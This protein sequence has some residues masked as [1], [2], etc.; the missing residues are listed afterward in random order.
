M[1]RGKA[2]PKRNAVN[3]E[4]TMKTNPLIVIIAV[5]CGIRGVLIA[6][7]VTG[8][9]LKV[10]S[11]HILEAVQ[12]SISGGLN[13]TIQS[14]AFRSAI[15]GGVYNQV[16][17]GATGSVI[18]GG[19]GNTIQT[20]AG[21]ST[22]AGGDGNTIE[23]GAYR[24]TIA[25]GNGNSVQ[26]N[27]VYCT[28]GGGLLNII[29]AD[30]VESFIGG[31]YGNTIQVGSGNSTIA[32]GYFN[33]IQ[34]DARWATISGGARNVVQTNAWGAT[35]GGGAANFIFANARGSTIGGGEHNTNR[36]WGGTIGGGFNNTIGQ[37]ASY[38]V[39]PGGLHNEVLAEFGLAAGYRAK[40]LNRGTFVWADDSSDVDFASTTPYQFLIRASG[41]VGIGTASPQAQLDVVSSRNDVLRLSGGV[42]ATLIEFNAASTDDFKLG[43]VTSLGG[44]GLKNMTDDRYDLFVKDDGNVGIGKTDP[45]AKLDVA[46]K[47]NCTVLELTSDRAQKSDFAPVDRRAILDQLARL[48]I[49]TWHYTNEP[50]VRHIGPVAQDFK[51]AFNVGSDDKHIA[52]VDA[53]GVALAAI[54]ALNDK[55][56]T[57]AARVNALEKEN[58]RLRASE[59]AA[60]R[61][62]RNFDR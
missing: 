5:V 12:S 17:D 21:Y 30:A 33:I 62:A 32:G 34:R 14:N 52:T 59:T 57:L 45:Q 1:V 16:L 7:D 37:T 51:A 29:Q 23:T 43:T 39:I 18:G 19:G 9:R 58:A 54:Q 38:A 40:A 47:V 55:V 6:D 13:N 56:E 44:L 49:T 31:G 20:N 46:G 61:E 3:F 2:R 50:A 60:L 41:G 24:S 53:D 4:A 35:I 25:G 28:I 48:P 27:A 15:G 8:D 26:S 11:D 10:G 42:T 22:I 36:S